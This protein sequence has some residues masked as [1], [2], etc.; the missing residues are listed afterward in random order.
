MSSLWVRPLK[1][2]G[3]IVPYTCVVYASC[4]KLGQW[5]LRPAP[6]FGRDG[7]TADAMVSEHLRDAVDRRFRFGCYPTR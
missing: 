4:D 6:V 7:R 3:S 2:T 5:Q 1:V